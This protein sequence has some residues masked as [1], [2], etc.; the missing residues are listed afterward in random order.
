MGRG[1]NARNE[2]IDKKMEN[3]KIAKKVYLG[4]RLTAEEVDRL[5]E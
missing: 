2:R 4:R 1:P 5:N 3:D